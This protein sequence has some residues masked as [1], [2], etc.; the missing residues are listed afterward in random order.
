VSG[1][2][3]IRAAAFAILLLG[4]L[5]TGL[6]SPSTGRGADRDCGDFRTQGEAQRYFVSR[7]GPHSDPD[8]LDGDGDGIACD[9]LPCPCLRGTPGPAGGRPQRIAAR[10]THVVD[11]DTLDVRA[12]GARREHY[13][14]RLIGIDTPEK[15]FGIECGA[16]PASRAMH[17]RA[18]RGTRVVLIT[19]PTQD[20]FDRYGRLLAYVQR[21]RDG[22]DLN[23]SQ[24][25]SGWASVYVYESPFRRVASYRHAA[26]RARAGDLGVWGRCGGNFHQPI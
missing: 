21:R 6:A 16:R 2:G 3:P 25:R 20:T 12:F 17:R 1:L 24:V 9:A 5:S 23:R 18:P 8:R 14:V 19:D 7:G 22:R 13:S 26:S 15:Y 10:V 4:L 11:G